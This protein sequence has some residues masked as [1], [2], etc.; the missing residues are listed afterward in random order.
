LKYGIRYHP[1]IKK[2]L[3]NIDKDIIGKFFD[4]VNSR[5]K[6]NPYVGKKLKGKYINLWRLKV[7]NYRIIYQIYGKKL[8]ILI[9]SFRHRQ[10]IYDSGL[11]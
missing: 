9:L 8:M 2:D 10:N 6:E 11:F 1:S 7:G 4:A 5:L 3:A